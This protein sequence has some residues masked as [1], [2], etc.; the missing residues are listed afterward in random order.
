MKRKEDVL[1]AL[2]KK[3]DDLEKD[4]YNWTVKHATFSQQELSLAKAMKEKEKQHLNELLLVEED[5]SRQRLR[6]LE[7]L[8][9]VAKEEMSLMDKTFEDAQKMLGKNRT[10]QKM[11]LIHW[12]NVRICIQPLGCFQFLYPSTGWF[13]FFIS[14]QWMV[15]VFICIQLNYY[16]KLTV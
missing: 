8:E 13:Q 6:A 2:Q 14:I 7:V 1:A 4:H 11:N 15:S 3:I 10:T 9:N 16:Q 5:I 12:G